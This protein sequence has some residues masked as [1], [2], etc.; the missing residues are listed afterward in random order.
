MKISR[1]GLLKHFGV[2]AIIAPVIGSGTQIA[3]AAKLLE[4]P[5]V[6]PVELFKRIP[7]PI[8]ASD[9]HSVT[10]ILECV[11][12]SKQVLKTNSATGT[13]SISPEQELHI[14]IFACDRN[15]SPLH[16]GQTAEIRTSG[17]V[18]DELQNL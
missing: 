4:L 6:E 8:L 16:Y 15:T 11:D 10:M 18:F 9:I 1:R 7:K 14:R 13:G 2:G 12:G 17:V 5:K 3:S